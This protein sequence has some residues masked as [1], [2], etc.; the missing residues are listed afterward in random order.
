VMAIAAAGTAHRRAG[1]REITFS[2]RDVADVTVDLRD[3]PAAKAGR[4]RAAN[5][6][7]T[8][9]T[10]TPASAAAFA[11]AALVRYGWKPTTQV[12]GAFILLRYCVFAGG[13]NAASTATCDRAAP[14]LEVRAAVPV[15]YIDLRDGGGSPNR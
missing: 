12:S 11:R 7:Y 1:S 13:K 5:I 2:T 9:Q 14:M 8:K 10:P 4:L 6:T 15:S 3:D